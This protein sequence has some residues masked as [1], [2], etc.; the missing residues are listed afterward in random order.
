MY[1]VSRL[2][3]ALFIAAIL[4]CVATVS[5]TTYTVDGGYG[6]YN[7][8]QSMIDKA[9]DGDV[10]YVKSGKY[11]GNLHIDK[12]IELI[13]ESSG[14]GLPQ[15]YGSGDE[16]VIVLAADEIRLENLDISG[17]EGSA[18][19]VKSSG[20]TITGNLI[21]DSSEG[22]FLFSSGKNIISKNQFLRNEIG[23]CLDGESHD[24]KVFL[25]TFE[26]SRNIRSVVTGN[27]W[28]HDEVEYEYKNKV[29][30]SPL[31][32]YWND[33]T[34]SDAR[35]D[36]IGD[37][38]YSI[39]GD[40]DDT[41]SQA[42]YDKYPLVSTAENYQISEFIEYQISE[43]TI[44][45]QADYPTNKDLLT[46]N[47]NPEI[48]SE[49]KPVEMELLSVQGSG[50]STPGL[51]YLIYVL[52]SMVAFGLIYLYGKESLRGFNT[53][54]SISVLV[55][56][57]MLE[58]IL[59]LGL[60]LNSYILVES[61]PLNKMAGIILPIS[62]IA[63]FSMVFLT[64]LLVVTVISNIRRITIPGL[65][66]AVYIIVPL[67]CAMILAM[68]LIAPGKLTDERLAII[69]LLPVLSAVVSYANQVFIK[70]RSESEKGPLPQYSTGN[71]YNS[72][73]FSGAADEMRSFPQALSSRYTD[74]EFI[75]KG[76]VA[77]VFRAKGLSDG[78]IVAVKVPL[79]FDEIT[80]KCFMKEIRIWQN[81][82]HPNIVRL[83]SVN[84]LPIP[85]LEMEYVENTLANIHTP[86]SIAEAA[87]IIM[88]VGK[89]LEYA[90]DKGIVHRDI[91]LQNI[92]IDREGTPKITDWGL[93]GF[94]YE[95]RETSVSGFSLSF[96]APEQIAPSRFGP[97][98]ERTDIYQ[99]CILLYELVTGIKPFEE[100]GIAEMSDAI[101]HRYPIPPSAINPALAPLDPV[102]KKA[103]EKEP[104]SRYL[105][106]TAFM[107]ELRLA[108]AG[109]SDETLL[110]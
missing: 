51:V 7:A 104:A 96:A 33:Y 48:V 99:M 50:D 36:G 25:N 59:I 71:K 10:I 73:V 26:N 52:S 15:L 16:A 75:G 43:K 58:C 18:V 94:L 63:G 103:L 9:V 4:C 28:D 93:G 1:M 24:N 35:G 69:I 55:L 79:G 11:F 47:T 66:S 105:S 64:F 101:L 39:R 21:H 89:G 19:Y 81:L 65:F 56:V 23:L 70:N 57:I 102:V 84:I 2:R 100:G 14:S 31:G 37:T 5:A 40:V 97:S 91:K 106:V 29:F 17:N 6:D 41:S 49:S 27:I 34:G 53:A 61:F 12:R 83:Y 62:F 67:C 20:N 77:R 88:G 90:H 54:G 13:G 72:T 85:F 107:R 30:K 108:L 92:L 32:N 86:L 87:R 110:F 60:I 68:Q 3:L 95:S 42:E 82:R 109:Y 8:I 45:D 76:G 78:N 44:A 98:D 46:A 74:A 38:P 22:L 80:G